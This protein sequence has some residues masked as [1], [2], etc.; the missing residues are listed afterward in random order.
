MAG[1]VLNEHRISIDGEEHVL[2][3][4]EIRFYKHKAPRWRRARVQ[5]DGSW[6]CISSKSW[7]SLKEAYDHLF[8]ITLSK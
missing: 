8:F 4:E 3:L 1:K 5:P 2:F 7:A 6:M